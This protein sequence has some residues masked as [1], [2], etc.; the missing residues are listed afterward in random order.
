MAGGLEESCQVCAPSH[1]RCLAFHRQRLILP[2]HPGRVADLMLAY[3]A[4]CSAPPCLPL[5]CVLL[6]VALGV[7]APPRPIWTGVPCVFSMCLPP[8]ARAPPKAL[9]GGQ[10]V[11]FQSLLLSPWL[12]CA[13]LHLLL[14]FS[15]N[16]Y[17]CVLIA[18]NKNSLVGVS[19]SYISLR[20]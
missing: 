6:Q 7:P 14:S 9:P 17:S 2:V 18:N 12:P 10:R 5:T 13:T 20:S 3:W 16:R 19:S 15:L 8:A 11:S 4:P 1:R